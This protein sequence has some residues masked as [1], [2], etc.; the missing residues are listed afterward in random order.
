MV[1]ESPITYHE[2]MYPL[3]VGYNCTGSPKAVRKTGNVSEIGAGNEENG[4]L[5]SQ[6]WGRIYGDSGVIIHIFYTSPA[7]FGTG[8]RKLQNFK[9]TGISLENLSRCYL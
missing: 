1:A 8:R 3:I 4:L 6:W 9:E 5:G 2:I 7:E